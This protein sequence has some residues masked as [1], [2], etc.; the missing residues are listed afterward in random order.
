MNSSRDINVAC[1]ILINGKNEILLQKKTVD[2]KLNPGCWALFG[3]EIHEYE[4]PQEAVIREIKEETSLLINPTF[5]L[6]RQCKIPHGSFSVIEYI[7]TA[8]TD[9][10]SNI[11]LTEGAGFAYFTLEEIGKLVNVWP[12]YEILKGAVT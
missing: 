9:G 12:D 1:C 6:K 7:F 2:Y 4:D 10:T 11:C 3:G 8:T 5:Y